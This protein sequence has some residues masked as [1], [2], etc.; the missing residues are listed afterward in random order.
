MSKKTLVT[1]H[2]HPDDESIA[3]GGVM[4]KAAADGHRVVLVVATKGEVGEVAEGFLAPGETLTERRVAET[5]RAAEV[6]G[7]ARVEFLGYRDSGMAGTADNDARGS[8]WSADVEEAAARLAKLLA[9][10]KADVLTVYDENGTYGHPDHIQ[11]HRVGVRAAELAS[12]PRVYETTVNRDHTIELMTQRRQEIFGDDTELPGGMDEAD[13]QAMGVPASRIT[14]VV[15]VRDYVDQKREA[16][17]QHASQVD[18]TSFFLSIPPEG[19]L[20]VFGQE[21]F[22]RRDAPPGLKESTLFDD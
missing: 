12:V 16:L 18:E 17:I 1:F 3:T 21:W 5:Q 13:M 14:T 8:F 4:A 9:E 2:A 10:E 19:F 22:I 20:A 6:L 7:V 15:D 11:V